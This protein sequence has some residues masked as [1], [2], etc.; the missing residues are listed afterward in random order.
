MFRYS[1]II[2]AYTEATMVG[3]KFYDSVFFLKFHHTDETAR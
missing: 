3:S 2:L 1:K